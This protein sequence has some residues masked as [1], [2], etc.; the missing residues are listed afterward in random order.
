MCCNIYLRSNKAG[1]GVANVHVRRKPLPNYLRNVLRLDSLH[2]NIFEK[3]ES[4][5]SENNLEMYKMLLS[6]K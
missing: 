3:C 1:S 2:Q 4:E 6:R 5:N